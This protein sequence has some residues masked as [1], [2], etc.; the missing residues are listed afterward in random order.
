MPVQGPVIAMHNFKDSVIVFSEEGVTAMKP[1]SSPAPT[2]SIV[3]LE[4]G[5]LLVKGAVGGNDKELVYVDASGSLVMIRA[6]LS[7]EV[8]GYKEYIFPLIGTDIA[9]S[10]SK[11][12]Q[13]NFIGGEYFISNGTK[14][15][16]LTASGLC[17]TWQIVTSAAFFQGASIGLGSLEPSS[18][19]GVGRV[20][21][22]ATDMGL[23]SGLKTLEWVRVI[24]NERLYNPSDLTSI[25][26]SI[27]YRYTVKENDTWSSTPY[28]NVNNE[29]WVE[30][31]VTALDHRINIK[32]GDYELADI[33]SFKTGFKQGDRR[34][35][36]S[37]SF[38]QVKT[39]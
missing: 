8:L 30:F 34:F 7:V 22:E 12:T 33:D 31:P 15:Y 18:A 25:Q 28:K 26:V 14:N 23:V 19:E 35:K 3:D 4:L 38:D 32:V 2:Y 17:E 36:R 37:I 27:D 16:H 29:G 5:G 39:R 10:Y 24:A 20:G 1:V 13:D 21:I 6:D 11:N 9:V